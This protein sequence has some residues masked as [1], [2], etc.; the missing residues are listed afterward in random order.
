MNGRQRYRSIA[1]KKIDT[2]IYCN[3]AVLPSSN[4]FHTFTTFLAWKQIS[5]VVPP[6]FLKKNRKHARGLSH[7][8]FDFHKGGIAPSSRERG[9]NIV[10]LCGPLCLSFAAVFR[11]FFPAISTVV[12]IFGKGNVFPEIGA[13]VDFWMELIEQ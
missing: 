1:T 8:G 11:R 10:L 12:E 7:P 13:E 9:G 6:V 4:R 2:L 5:G 3:S